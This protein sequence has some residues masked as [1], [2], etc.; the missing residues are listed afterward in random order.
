M[1][2]LLK[3]KVK[4]SW[5]IAPET[6]VLL[7]NREHQLREQIGD[8]ET[9]WR[10]LVEQQWPD[11]Q[12]PAYSDLSQQLGML[13]HKLFEAYE[14]LRKLRSDSPLWQKAQ[15][16]I[17]ILCES[18]DQILVPLLP[19]EKVEI[20]TELISTLETHCDSLLNRLTQH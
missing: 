6:Q 7:N 15:H 17:K 20:I 1:N 19:E 5:G 10:Q 4:D 11:R 8:L 9:R 16:E 2:D 12:K 13:E 14:D 18:L 3:K